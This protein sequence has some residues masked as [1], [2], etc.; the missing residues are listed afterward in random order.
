VRALGRVAR[1][2]LAL[3]PLALGC[4]SEPESYDYST[5]VAHLP[6][7]ILVLPPL[8][9]SLEVEAPYRWLSTI[10]YPLA[11]RGYYVFPVAL[12]DLYM[13]ENGLP[14]PHE[15]HDVPLAKL[16]EIFGCDAVLYVTITEWGTSYRVISSDTTVAFDARLVDAATG[17]ELWSGSGQAVESSSSGSSDIFSMLAG[18]VTQQI[19]ST[20]IADPS[21][22]LARQANARMIWTEGQ[23]LLPGPYL[24]VP[25]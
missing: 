9:L 21:T 23:G 1:A 16:A 20:T 22:G 7:S 24:P 5:Y 19:L 25:E 11:E 2:A 18:A 4:A 6:R 3:G 15:M 17:L 13:K 10:T 8:D 12:V 14:T